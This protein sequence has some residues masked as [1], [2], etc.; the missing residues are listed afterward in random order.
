MKIKDIKPNRKTV[1][2]LLKSAGCTVVLAFAITTGIRT[3][4]VPRKLNVLANKN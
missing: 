4:N 2:R 3:I 1:F